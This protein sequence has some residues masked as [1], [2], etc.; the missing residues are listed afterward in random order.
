MKKYHFY[1]IFITMFLF[2]TATQAQQNPFVGTWFFSTQSST[3]VMSSDYSFTAK[4]P[5]GQS[6][7]SYTWDANS[8]LYFMNP[9][10]QQVMAYYT[11]NAIDANSMT[12]TDP[13]GYQM[14]YVK[15]N[16]VQPSDNVPTT[17]TTGDD[18]APSHVKIKWEENQFQNVLS[19]S[20][21]LELKQSH[22]QIGVALL[23]FIIGQRITSGEVKELEKASIPEFDAQPQAF[24]NEIAEIETAMKQIYTV[25]DPVSIGTVRQQLFAALYLATVNMKEADK[26]MLIQVM[27]RYANV[28]NYD[29]QNNLVL[30]EMDVSG[31]TSYVAFQSQLM[32][33]QITE[34]DKTAY[35]NQLVAYFPHMSVQERQY[36]CSGNLIW[37]TVEGNWNSM[38]EQQQQ[39]VIV[40]YRQQLNYNTTTNYQDHMDAEADKWRKYYEEKYPITDTNGGKNTC[41]ECFK[42]M[43]DMQTQSHVTTM[44]IIENIGGSDNYWTVDYNNW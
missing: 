6:S 3:L 26:P 19:T 34:A 4:S 35:Q 40:Q 18:G 10:N 17:T 20:N 24:L 14:I 7:G 13:Y 42:I 8:V 5:T 15:Q 22:I 44:N 30:T 16:N 41:W 2:T 43:S 11:V 27:N 37:K 29:A 9:Q 32:G 1:S 36:I 23:E 39:Q 33:A 38:T 25:A 12:L 21:G 31:F 28:L